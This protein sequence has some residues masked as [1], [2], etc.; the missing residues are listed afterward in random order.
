[1]SINVKYLLAALAAENDDRSPWKRAPKVD[2]LGSPFASCAYYVVVCTLPLQSPIFPSR[3]ITW[4]KKAP[5]TIEQP[6]Q[7]ILN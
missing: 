3:N 6:L 5:K 2:S 1:M 4:Q 7:F